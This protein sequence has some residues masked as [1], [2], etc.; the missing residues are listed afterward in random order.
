MI[1]HITKNRIQRHKEFWIV[2]SQA[3]G[4]IVYLHPGN[5]TAMP[6]RKIWFV[7][8]CKWYLLSNMFFFVG[9]YVEF[10]GDR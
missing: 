6:K 3:N 5:L 8:V 1:F 7:D 9:I 2:F 10:Q 4:I